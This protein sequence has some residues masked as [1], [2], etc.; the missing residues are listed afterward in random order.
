MLL[1]TLR[2][3]FHTSLKDDYPDTE[4]QS[5]FNLLAECFLK[6][7]RMDVSLNLFMPISGK[8][9][10]K[11]ENAIKR[12]KNYEPVQ[13]IV[14]VTEFYGLPFKV[15]GSTLIP[16]PETEELV[17]WLID[18]TKLKPETL[19]ILD[20]GTG[21]GC[22]AVSLSKNMPSAIVYAVDVSKKAL[23]V[24]KTNAKLNKVDVQFFELDILNWN[25]GS[26]N[27]AFENMRFDIIVSNPPYVRH[28]EKAQMSPNVLR[29]EPGLALYVEDDDPLIFYKTITE[30]AA[31]HLE[32]NGQLFFEINQYLGTEMVQLLKDFNYINIELR[33]DIFGN[34]R[35]ISGTRMS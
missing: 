31:A 21:T 14:G 13:Y 20:I 6:M 27:F 23:T 30:F 5:F 22:I 15:T 17:Q 16:R 33:K 9:E 29:H 12:L 3:N 34:D 18:D 19:S 32:N 28:L 2:E 10:E 26:S 35:M 7:K 1:K 11:F 4:I 25:N 24:G 8:K